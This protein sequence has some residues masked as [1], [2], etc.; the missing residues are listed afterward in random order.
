MPMFKQANRNLLHDEVINAIIEG[1]VSGKL[2]SGD[3]I[4]EQKIATDM[5]ISRGP[6]REAIR[7]LVNQGVLH[8]RPHRGAVI[9]PIEVRNVQELFL[10]RSRL[11]GLSANLATDILTQKD[12]DFLEDLCKN[13]ENAILENDPIAY[14]ENDLHFHDVI[15]KRSDNGRLI[16]MMEGIQLQN[17]LL[18]YMTKWYMVAH[19]QLSL[20]R[21]AHRPILEVF[22]ARDSAMAEQN[23]REHIISA[24]D[25]LVEFIKNS[26]MMLGT[27]ST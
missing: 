6:V 26:N 15:V 27:G 23:M 17:R 25:V 3:R 13:M 8:F 22:Y 11:E 7:E 18:M 12:L 9:A 4:I 1:I 20:E 24:G 2:R 16:R 19:K 10:L 14:V 5:D 21:C